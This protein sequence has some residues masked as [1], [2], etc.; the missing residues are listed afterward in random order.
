[1]TL[2]GCDEL[3]RTSMTSSGI[4]LDRQNLESQLLSGVDGFG[5]LL[6][7]HLG[8]IMGISI[9]RK[10]KFKCRLTKIALK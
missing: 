4:S 10:K 8:G 9:K 1:M 2:S 6:L 7:A 3:I 5:N